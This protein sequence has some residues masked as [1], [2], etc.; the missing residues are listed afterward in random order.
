MQSIASCSAGGRPDIDH[1][2]DQ[3]L[4]DVLPGKRE[5]E[6]RHNTGQLWVGTSSRVQSSSSSV[7]EAKPGNALQSQ[8]WTL[9]HQRRRSNKENTDLRNT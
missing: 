6:G 3:C 7:T 8:A 4:F 1:L 9:P 2:E 5:T